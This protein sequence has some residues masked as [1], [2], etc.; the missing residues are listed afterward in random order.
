MRLFG[1]R[2]MLVWN[3]DI[4]IRLRVGAG[5]ARPAGLRRRPL[6]FCI[7]GRGL[8]PS[9][10]RRGRRPLQR[11]PETIPTPMHARG[12]LRAGRP[13]ISR[14]PPR[15]GGIHPSRAAF[16]Y[17]LP[18]GSLRRG[19]IYAAR[20]SRPA[21]DQPSTTPVGAGH[22][23]PATLRCRPLLFCI[24]GRGLDPSAG[25]RGRRPLQRRPATI[26]TPM[27]TRGGL[28]AGRPTIS[29]S[30]HPVGEGFIPPGPLSVIAYLPVHSVGA[31]YM[32]PAPPGQHP[33]NHPPPP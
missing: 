29:R 24:V 30:R 27:H 18:A 33:I 10:G 20:P 9:A 21:P 32:P 11:W 26:P 17:S 28:R 1:Y 25:R 6:L 14:S 5:H 15:R 23:R 22:A 7:V 4:A 13:T 12:S 2:M 16:G 19:G 31:A 3:T 8:D